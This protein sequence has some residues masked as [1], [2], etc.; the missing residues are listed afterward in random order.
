M[1]RTTTLRIY[2]LLQKSLTTTKPA[3][4]VRFMSKHSTES[5]EDFDKRL[6]I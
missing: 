4:P 5:D 6:I 3:V 1:L 2:S